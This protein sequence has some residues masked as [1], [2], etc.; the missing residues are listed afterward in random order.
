M[1]AGVSVIMTVL[2]EAASL[3]A[4]LQGLEQQTRRPDEVVVVDGGSTDGT[5]ALLHGYAGPLTLRVLELPGANIS[6]GRN[7]AI[8]A[9]TGPVIA[10]T[11]AGVRLEPAWLAALVQPMEDDGAVAVAGFF[12]SDPAGLF[13]AVLGATTL[14]AASDVNPATFL[15]SSRSVAVTK[16]VWRRAGGYPEWLDYCEDLLFD[17]AVL[18][19][20]VR[21]AWA[22][23]AL[24]HFRPRPTLAAFFKQ[25]Y[26]YA[27]GDG[28]AGL[29]R[30][31]HAI[32][33]ATYAAGALATL[34][35]PRFPWLLPA[36]LAA[37]IGYCATP[38]RRLRPWLQGRPASVWCRAL[39]LVPLI[40]LTGDVA[41]LL[42]YPA[43]L[44]WRLR[45]PA[46][47]GQR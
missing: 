6:Q 12:H 26:R 24:A 39:P 17:F 14:P 21:F 5:L 8:E 22:P 42:G 13:E 37:G 1:R 19:L 11:D 35:V 10:I 2:N 44:W 45:N 27:R 23:A 28:K 29:W 16:E 43:G 47:R 38:I 3:P 20:G 46:S 18:N 41:K 7:A 4:V 15:P 9:A 33:Y 40:R 36:M 34:A 30:R 32:R 25:Y 31:R